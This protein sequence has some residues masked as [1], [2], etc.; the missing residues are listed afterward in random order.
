MK[1]TDVMK[2]FIEKG[3]KCSTRIMYSD[4]NKLYYKKKIIGETLTTGERIIYDF[5]GRHG[6]WV[7]QGLANI[8]RS[9]LRKKIPIMN[10]N[11]LTNSVNMLYYKCTTNGGNMRVQKFTPRHYEKMIRSWPNIYCKRLLLKIRDEYISSNDELVSIEERFEDKPD[12]PMGNRVV[13]CKAIVKIHDNK[14]GF[15]LT[16]L[17]EK[18]NGSL[19]HPSFK[20]TVFEVEENQVVLKETEVKVSVL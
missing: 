19:N 11:N 1:N 3:T 15:T 2:Y 5:S 10:K 20:T 14:N 4:G 12:G 9:A 6:E 17:I 13:M 7:D 16:C 8:T 18:P